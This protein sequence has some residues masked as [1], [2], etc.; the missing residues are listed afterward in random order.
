VPILDSKRDCN[1]KRDREERTNNNG[2]CLVKFES[3]RCGIWLVMNDC[4]PTL[5]WVCD[6][7]VEAL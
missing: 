1:A 5:V 7:E 4:L 3:V 6:C 2:Y